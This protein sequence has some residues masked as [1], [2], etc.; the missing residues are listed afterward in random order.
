MRALRGV[1]LRN[2][3]VVLAVTLLALASGRPLQAQSTTD[4]DAQVADLFERS[5]ARAGCHAGP[6][7]MMNL[8]LSRDQHYAALV[9]EA[10]TENPQI[11][12]VEPG[13]PDQSYII[14]KL[15]GEPG[16]VGMQMP[17][18][19]DKLTPDEI[20]LIE[21]WIAGMGGVDESRKAAA[22]AAE[23]YPFYGWKVMNLPTSRTLNAGNMLFMI[24]H[25]FNPR[26][27]DG[28]SAFFGLDGSA[29]IYLSLGYAI[30]DNLL[31]ALARSNSADDVE[32]SARYGLMRQGGARNWPIGASLQTTANWITQTN[33]G[34]S[35][36]EAERLKFTAQLSLTRSIMDRIGLAV[37]P[38]VLVNQNEIETDEPLLVTVGLGARWRFAPKLSIIGEWVPIVSG[39]NRSLIF[40]NDIRYD[41]WGG[42]LEISTAGHVFQ[43]VVANAV[44]L[45][46]DQYLR[47][48]DLGIENGDIRLGFNIFRI[49]TP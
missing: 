6:V 34:E 47:G 22:P 2:A 40:G 5:C 1:S 33:E 26:I 21:Q 44:G 16:I 41:S 9:G 8:D 46:T 3:G 20:G 37:V 35:S 45:T 23:P 29:I 19:G 15:K 31:V 28:Y 10:S 39:Y 36:F 7:P 17:F 30:T 18:T 12:R 32:L 11:K 24:G 38:G 48:G 27:S 42:G 4:L 49:L 14:M 43:I 13:R 25:R